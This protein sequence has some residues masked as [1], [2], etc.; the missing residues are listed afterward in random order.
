MNTPTLRWKEKLQKSLPASVVKLQKHYTQVMGERAELERLTN[1]FTTDLNAKGAA[2]LLSKHRDQLSGAKLAAW[3]EALEHL[4]KHPSQMGGFVSIDFARLRL[5]ESL[6]RKSI[7]D[8]THAIEAVRED[9]TRK[10]KELEDD[11]GVTVRI[12]DAERSLLSI[13]L[14]LKAARR[15]LD[16]APDVFGNVVL[17]NVANQVQ[18][19]T[20]S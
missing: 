10:A 8:L 2:S 11:Y 15:Q 16:Q 9:L 18:G 19:V 5:D 14:S 7:D 13:L 6:I 20:T 4:R 17:L 3:D 1:C 12:G